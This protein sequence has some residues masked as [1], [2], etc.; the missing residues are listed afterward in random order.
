MAL[1]FFSGLLQF[2]WRGLQHFSGGGLQQFL[3]V[4]LSFGL[5]LSMY[6]HLVFLYNVIESFKN[7]VPLVFIFS[8]C[9][10]LFFISG[11]GF[12][13]FDSPISAQRA[14]AALQSKGIQA[15]MA[16][17]SEQLICLT[18]SLVIL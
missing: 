11:Y 9:F 7:P 10:Q 12:V 6:F 1:E 3:P 13:D 4:L 15:Q 14:V 16:R 2:L 17:V 5:F 8:K 18:S